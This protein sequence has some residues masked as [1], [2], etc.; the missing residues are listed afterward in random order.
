MGVLNIAIHNPSYKG[1]R[2]L[3]R[4]KYAAPP[5]PPC[6]R[7]CDRMIV[8]FTTTYTIRAY[9][10]KSFDFEPRSVRGV[11]NTT[12][13]FSKF[14]MNTTCNFQ[15]KVTYIK[16]TN[17][18]ISVLRRKSLKESHDFFVHNSLYFELFIH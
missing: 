13:F 18:L 5:P 6:R 9:H 10:C 3:R 15:C 2:P 7:R 12:S 17:T 14:I 4:N 16:I 1:H 8:G 11:L